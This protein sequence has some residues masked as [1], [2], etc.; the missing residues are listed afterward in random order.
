MSPLP[1]TQPRQ[2]LDDSQWLN[3]LGIDPFWIVEQVASASS[4]MA[5]ENMEIVSPT[6][7]VANKQLIQSKTDLLDWSALEKGIQECQ[8][9]ELFKTRKQAVLGVGDR[10]A[11]W[12]IVGEAPGAEEDI[13]GL[14]FVGKAGKLLDA[15]LAALGLNRQNGV[16]IANAVKCRPP[17]NRTPEIS[18][19]DACN[20]FLNQQIEWIQPKVIL[21]LGRPAA[22]AVL[23]RE[24]SIQS[25]RGAVHFR[26]QGG[27]RIPV[28]VSYHPAYLLRQPEEKWKSWQDLL[29]AED[30]L[31][32]L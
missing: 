21:A 4:E 22:Y 26:Q 25:Q 14:P 16:Y 12:L 28:V 3:A 18:E 27:T 5:S 15:M 32:S 10:K 29:L 19:I 30:S 7:L 24:A 17:G 11:T 23:G 9:C 6:N 31:K 1:K 2:I 8:S 20:R 13:A